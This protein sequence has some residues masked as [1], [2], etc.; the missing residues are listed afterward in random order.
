[1]VRKLKKNGEVG[2]LCLRYCEGLA[3]CEKIGLWLANG[4]ARGLCP[5]NS[6]APSGV[7]YL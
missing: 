6:T 4:E 7:Q 1:M 2:G 5:G 3:A